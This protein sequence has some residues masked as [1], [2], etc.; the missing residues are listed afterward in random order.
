MEYVCELCD[1]FRREPMFRERFER[2][3]QRLERE[4]G[5]NS[6][7]CYLTVCARDTGRTLMECAEDHRR[8]QREYY[9][10]EQ[11]WREHAEEGCLL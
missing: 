11:F 10:R 5:Y 3:P 7:T 9:G 2:R 8:A 4:R 6:W 1:L